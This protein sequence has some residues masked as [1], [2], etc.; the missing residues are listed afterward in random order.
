VQYLVDEKLRPLGLL[1]AAD[2][3]QPKT[4]KK[5]PLLALKLKVVITD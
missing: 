1:V 4:R 2:G 5:N 3:V